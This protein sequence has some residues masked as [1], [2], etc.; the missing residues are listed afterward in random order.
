MDDK[1]KARRTTRTPDPKGRSGE[2]GGAATL[3][4]AISQDG[5]AL[6]AIE[7]DIPVACLAEADCTAGNWEAA[8]AVIA[9][10]VPGNGYAR[11]VCEIWL[12]ESQM[13]HR[14]A[15]LEGNGPAA[16][17]AAA[18]SALSAST[19]FRAEA[20]A[21]DV[22]QPDAEGYT[23]I[24]AIP[25]E[26]LREAEALARRTNM[27]PERVTTSDDIEGF[28][29][30][31]A[32]E[33]P[34]AASVA[35]PIAMAA[36]L[37]AALALPVMGYLGLGSERGLDFSS[38]P[39]LAAVVTFER[40][41]FTGTTTDAAP[42]GAIH[43]AVQV[44]AAAVGAAPTGQ[45]NTSENAL[46]P[47]TENENLWLQIAPARTPDREADLQGYVAPEDR[48][49]P[50]APE[51]HSA[52]REQL[53][54]VG[55]PHRVIQKA[56]LKRWVALDDLAIPTSYGAA[57][58]A[59]I[60]AFALP[61]LPPA[62]PQILPV[63]LLPAPTGP[64]PAPSVAA[65][66]MPVIATLFG[67]I[68]FTRATAQI[69]RLY[70]R[71]Y[72]GFAPADLPHEVLLG[73]SGAPPGAAMSR[74]TGSPGIFQTANVG[75]GAPVGRPVTRPS[76]DSGQAVAQAATEPSAGARSLRRPPWRAGDAEPIPPFLPAR[77]FDYTRLDRLVQRPAAPDN[78]P[79]PP[80]RLAQPG[81]DLF[82]PG[83]IAPPRV[84]D[85][86]GQDG[87]GRAERREAAV[88]RAVDQAGGEGSFVFRPAAR[89]VTL[90][91]EAG[92]TG[93]VLII[94]P[95]APR[96]ISGEPG[97]D[98][99]KG[100]SAKPLVEATPRSG[101]RLFMSKLDKVPVSARIAALSAPKPL[102]RRIPPARPGQAAAVAIAALEA[103][104]EDSPQQLPVAA[105]E[106][107]VA[108]DDAEDQN[109]IGPV[110]PVLSALVRRL[111]PQRP[112]RRP[113]SRRKPVERSLALA[114][115]ARLDL[116]QIT[117]P[118]P[119]TPQS[120]AEA[121]AE[122]NA[123]DSTRANIAA[124][125]Q[126]VAASQ[127][128]AQAANA[129]ATRAERPSP[130]SLVRPPAPQR[131]LI[132]ALARRT[133]PLR[134]RDAL[135][136][137][138]TAPVA[139]ESAQPQ[140]E[141]VADRA[142]PPSPAAIAA[143]RLALLRPPVREGTS[144]IARRLPPVR[145]DLADDPALRAAD[146]SAAATVDV[147][148]EAPDADTQTAATDRLD[149]PRP[150]VR[151][152]PDARSDALARLAPP[153]RP[154]ARAS[155]TPAEPSAAPLS[156]DTLAYAAPLAR[157]SGLRARA[158]AILAARAAAKEQV[159]SRQQPARTTPSDRLSIPGNAR[160]GSTATVSDGI[161]LGDL[162]LIGIFGKKNDRRALIRLP[163]GRVIK[164]E[165]GSQVSGWTVSAI[166]DDGVRIQKGN[167]N[168]TLRLPN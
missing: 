96:R 117:P 122:A 120:A 161:V 92:T 31:P 17:R 139:Q 86:H 126:S 95:D 47:L 82:A 164:V 135:P 142:E 97:P 137:A 153:G 78:T 76:F 134:A 11:P 40:P 53:P 38:R 156:G 155:V 42:E 62:P 131:P 32:F 64:E 7:R 138:N 107:V 37:T 21:F 91:P 89:R 23:P 25:L 30:R 45:G 140:S 67:P 129:P 98:W 149:R 162:A 151:A 146:T 60:P 110:E 123:G 68:E 100:L 22:G 148:P 49:A 132:A 112:G 33:V 115:I 34:R 18:S 55:R 28:A 35:R 128:P 63:K 87:V 152:I 83:N 36:A 15:R 77:D 1:A 41:V 54:F 74:D 66:E 71:P 72:A 102:S 27:D 8:E 16:L 159:S 46:K 101:V 130:A 143:D 70:L 3:A 141:A 167:R 85:G 104:R 168:Q 99:L 14:K 88:M 103:V 106:P 51:D 154:A 165:R 127:T 94:A 121:V 4:L 61:D 111:P 145:S 147:V 109:L 84:P 52:W 39:L 56:E 59:K 158:Q 133:P 26:R 75:E 69:E 24:A 57:A 65:E 150:P 19:A 20:L 114:R 90:L 119:E 58:S 93:R 125:E 144:S 118:Q 73:R 43:G 12:D 13:V 105:A 9:A 79:Q 44:E 5:L 50:L 6:F 80:D 10:A 48:R 116:P 124:P 166:A 157:P 29:K 108:V 2:S 136:A 113:I 81:P 160:V 163:Q